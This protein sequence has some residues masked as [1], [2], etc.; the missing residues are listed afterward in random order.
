MMRLQMTLLAVA[1]LALH[2]QTPARVVTP[3]TSEGSPWTSR[4]GEWALPAAAQGVLEAPAWWPGNRPAQDQGAVLEFEYLDSFA[5]PAR[6]EVY[7]GM[8][9]SR[10]YS[11]LHRFGGEAD[12][13]WKQARIPAT[14]DLLFAFEPRHTARF[15]LTA[16]S[17]PLRA[18]GFRLAAPRDGDKQRYDAETRAWIA[19]EQRRAQVHPEGL[20]GKQA[21]VL[22]PAWAASPLVPYRRNWMDLVRPWSAPQAGESVEGLKVRLFR[23]EMEPL[24]LGVF[25]NGRKLSNV[26]VSVQPVTGADG[27]AIVS[28]LPRVAEYA[29][30]RSSITTGYNLSWFPQR[31]WPAYPFDVAA[32]T[33]GMVWLVLGTREDTSRSGLYKTSVRFTADGLEDVVVPLTIEVLDSRLLT[34]EEAGLKLGGCT[35]GLVPEFELRFLRAYNHNMVN[36]WYQS[37]R[38]LLARQGESFSMDFRVMDDWMASARRAGIGDLVYFLG[39]DPYIFPRTMRLGESLAETVLGIDGNGWAALSE[40]NRDAVPEKVAPLMVEWSRRFAQHAREAGWPNVILTPFDE[41]AKHV[42]YHQQLG[43]L[44]FIRPQFKQQVGLLR[45]GAPQAQIYGSIHHYAPGIGFLEDIDVFCTN[46]IAENPR[47]PEEVLGAGKTFWEYSG[48]TDSGLPASAR[49]TFGFYFA[50]HGSTGSL[51]WAYNWGERFD[52]LDGSNWM[53]AWNTPFDVIPSPYMEG[54]REAWDDRRLIESVRQAAKKRG[55]DISGFLGRLFADVARAR[56]VG[57]NDTVNDFW[58]RSTNDRLMDE[59]R[60]RLVNEL[61]T[62]EKQ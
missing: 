13:K 18:R 43:M 35:T 3:L 2:A 61:L 24:Q 20:P 1:T 4:D 14:P 5:H 28:I 11:E 50:S 53:Y 10:P 45:Q 7:G 52:T 59:W 49:Y 55:V 48:T 60:E 39:G 37:V 42:Q 56:G 46:A 34:M 15:R 33:S 21:P 26:Q 38:P 36:I 31:L 57:G 6:A 54:M 17:G 47:L 44:S 16:A 32:G 40:R 51:V 12:G 58:D 62:L 27:G 29:K 41:P 22:A 9:T 30:V 19:R 23:N 8:G 25:A